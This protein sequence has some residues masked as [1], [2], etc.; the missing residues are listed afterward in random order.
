MNRIVPWFILVCLALPM[1]G[2]AEETLPPWWSQAQAQAHTDG[3]S[4]L[5]PVALDCQ[6]RHGLAFLL[7]DVR[8]GYEYDRGHIDGAVNF[9][10][11]L[12]DRLVLK[13]EKRAA[14]EGLLGP[15][16]NRNIV[17]YCRSFR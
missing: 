8:P 13:P 9:E 10:F 16:K 1:A 7:V 12:A 6:I 3:Y 14:F 17:F 5:T 2:H 11:N 4:L 15:D